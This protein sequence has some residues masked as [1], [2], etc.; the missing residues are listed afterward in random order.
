V[1]LMS[2]LIVLSMLS[3]LSVSLS[4]AEHVESA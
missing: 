4:C 3:V 1:C 2:V